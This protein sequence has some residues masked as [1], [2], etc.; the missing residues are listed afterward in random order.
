MNDLKTRLEKE[1]LSFVEKPSRYT[2][3]EWNSIKKSPEGKTR[4]VLIYPDVY[5]IGISN[6]G[7][8]ILYNILS[9]R[10]DIYCE[11]AY[12]PW[13][14][15]EKILRENRLPLFSLETKTPLYKF[16]I[17]G[18]SIQYELTISNVLNILDI[19]KIP[20]FS[21]ERTTSD[22]PFIVAGGPVVSNPEPYALFM[23]AIVIGDGETRII[24]V[25]EIIKEG[26]K[27][28]LPRVEILKRLALVKGCYVPSLYEVKEEKGYCIPQGEKV[29]RYIEPNIN[30][31]PFPVNQIV[32]NLQA[33]QDRAVIEVSRG[34]TRGCRFCHAGIIY[35]PLREREIGEI[36]DYSKKIIESTGYREIALLSLSI[37][38]Y[39]HL[40]DL[41][42]ELEKIFSP[43]GI[44]LS[45][46]SLRL[47]SFT[48]DLA[49]K[50][51]EIRK[52]G[53]TFAV[54]GGSQEIRNYI[55]KNISEEELF[56][57]ISIAYELG[58]KSVKL[59]F[60]IG[61]LRNPEEEVYYISELAKKIS[62]NFK[63]LKITLSVA[64]FVPKPHT[65]FQWMG[66]LLPEEGEKAFNLLIS[67]LKGYRNV[68]IRYNSPQA[69]YLE[70]IFSR[71]DR[72]LAKVTER[73]FRSGCRFGWSEFLDFYVWQKAFEEE[74]VDAKFYLSSKDKETV[75]PW[76]IVDCGVKREFLYEEFKNALSQK[77]TPD[78]RNGCKSYCG[79]C[80]FKNIR[81]RPAENRVFKPSV[82]NF[83]SNIFITSEP[84]FS[85]RFVFKKIG[86]AR[87]FSTID[88]EN[89]LSY[90]LIRA[91]I[92]VCFT[93]GFNPHIKVKTLSALPVG[94][95][96]HYEIAEIELSRHEDVGK[97]V[98]DWNSVLPM[99]IEIINGIIFKKGE[100]KLNKLSS[101]Y[102]YFKI[103]SPISKE[104]IE[105]NYF[106]SEKFEKKTQ[107]TTRIITLKNYIK[108]WW[109]ED[110]L[111]KIVFLQK[112]GE[113]RLQ[114]VINGL[115]GLDIRKAICYKPEILS[116][117]LIVEDENIELLRAEL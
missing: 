92:P 86:N 100:K 44:S 33:V 70:G 51:K 89:H 55:N 39:S 29:K 107:K 98:T 16:D 108:E 57:S 76:E 3:N 106:L 12:A 60:M 15:M 74:N 87:Y 71:G 46:P 112:E 38:D 84:Q 67:F 110:G 35:R 94:V 79:N 82:D 109:V 90:S 43:H 41:I 81:N 113:A 22:I 62:A 105:K 54:E 115:L 19:S 10:E 75:F 83:L 53:L 50:T 1:V 59:Y 32:P 48:L 116:R 91:N 47:D 13:F 77:F 96:S 31:L 18:F 42:L 66:Q 34:C 28:K 88:L 11:R 102:V 6:L 45:L 117:F 37:S 21:D 5:E 73:A 52:T 97:I 25:V 2:G 56:R 72:K 101:H 9:E 4:V 49:K 58:W 65:P 8:K 68:N 63:E 99:G 114:D 7:L 104:E 61:F 23:D 17:I 78:C 27:S 64:I 36:I 85:L 24:E 20:L 14:D 26:K 95:E 93:K 80:D 30:K 103:E 40:K 111:V 69:S